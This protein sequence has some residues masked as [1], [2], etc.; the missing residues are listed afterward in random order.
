MLTSVLTWAKTYGIEINHRLAE[1]AESNCNR[2]AYQTSAD[3]ILASQL[4]QY[5]GSISF[6][7]TSHICHRV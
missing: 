4:E 6:Q 5:E 1:Y 7:I 3:S 2:S